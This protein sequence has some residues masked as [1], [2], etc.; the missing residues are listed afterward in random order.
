MITRRLLRRRM[1][2][3]WSDRSPTWGGGRQVYEAYLKAPE[4]RVNVAANTHRLFGDT[5]W[6]CGRTKRQAEERN[7][8]LTT[9]HIVY[10]MEA[11]TEV[12]DPDD[13]TRSDVILLCWTH[14]LFFDG[15]SQDQPFY[16]VE[17]LR[18]ASVLLLRNMRRSC[19]DGQDFADAD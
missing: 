10:P 9:A 12:I 3:D 11:F 2:D 16:S 8:R 6:V 14:H 13:L 15:L 1:L 17:E 18:M 19:R 5:C 7:D 4:Y